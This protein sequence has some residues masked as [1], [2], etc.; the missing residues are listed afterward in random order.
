MLNTIFVTQGSRLELFYKVMLA[1]KEF[2]EFDKIGFYAVDSRFFEKFKKDQSDINSS[3]FSLLKEWDIIRDASNVKLDISI[4]KR[5]EIDIGEPC[6]WNALVADR[7]IYS[8]KKYTHSLDYKPRF[9]HEEML[10]I[11]QVGLERM[12]NLFSKVKPDFVVSFQCV[13]LGE[14]LSFLFAKARNIPF[15]NLKPTRIRNYIYAGEDVLEPSASLQKTYEKL[16]TEGMD[17]ALEREISTYLE[18]L[19]STNA[20]YEGVIPVSNR[21]PDSN[22][23]GRKTA[24]VFRRNK[25]L[26]S[27]VMSDIICKSG[28][29]KFDNSLNRYISN[30]YYKK[31]KRPIIARKMRIVFR[32][33]YVNKTDLESISYAL[34]PLH[35]EP[36]VTLNLYSKPYLNQ[37]EAVRLISHNLPVGMKLL[38]KEHPVCIGKRKISYYKKLLEIPN[39]LLAPPDMKSRDLINNADLITVISGSIGL[40]GLF[41]KV[42]VIVFGRAPFNF[43]PKKMIHYVKNPDTLGY[44]I[45]NLLKNHQHD[46]QAIKC[47]VGA[48]MKDSVPVDFYSILSGRPEAY[49]PNQLSRNSNEGIK[50]FE[51]QTKLLAKYLVDRYQKMLIMQ[52]TFQS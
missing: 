33:T 13:T 22:V 27:A 46:E 11:L 37:I 43:L 2:M 26:V 45:R 50:E 31:L 10:C 29:F 15:L 4:L 35:T 36:E 21:P 30:Y 8:G 14:Y 1:M 24:S 3:T 17:S 32:N 42:P 5:Y 28:D 23:L 7:K 44:E 12:D 20:M 39:V 38:V 49:N 25:A 34:F 19:R 51:N 6:L 9:S 40:E 41:M 16:M 47:Y 18:E 52:E 48:I